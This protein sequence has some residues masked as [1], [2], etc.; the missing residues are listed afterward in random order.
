MSTH[1]KKTEWQLKPR[2]P[3]PAAKL[4]TWIRSHLPQVTDIIRSLYIEDSMHKVNEQLDLAATEMVAIKLQLVKLLKA[5]NEKA[6]PTRW[7]Q[8]NKDY[9]ELC[10]EYWPKGYEEYFEA[11]KCDF[12]SHDVQKSHTENAI[13]R[14]KTELEEEFIK[15]DVKKIKLWV[16]PEAPDLTDPRF[17]PRV[18]R[19]IQAD[20]LPKEMVQ[21][22]QNQTNTRF[23]WSKYPQMILDK[24]KLSSLAKED[25]WQSWLNTAAAEL[26]AVQSMAAFFIVFNKWEWRT[27]ALE[28]VK[29]RLGI[30]GNK[31]SLALFWLFDAVELTDDNWPVVLYILRKGHGVTPDNYREILDSP[32]PV[33]TYGINTLHGAVKYLELVETGKTSAL[34]GLDQRASLMRLIALIMGD[35]SAW[36]DVGLDQEGVPW[37]GAEPRDV[38][39]CIC[40]DM[41]NTDADLNRYDSNDPKHMALARGPVKDVG[42]PRGF[43]AGK[44]T[45][46][47]SLLN[48]L[49][50]RDEPRMSEEDDILGLSSRI[51]WPEIYE[52]VVNPEWTNHQHLEM[53]AEKADII[54]S[55]INRNYP[56]LH[57]NNKFLKDLMRNRVYHGEEIRDKPLCKLPRMETPWGFK[58]ISL[59]WR[60]SA[61]KTNRI[62]TTVNGFSAEATVYAS[63]Y[64][65]CPNYPTQ[66]VHCTESI[67]TCRT[68]LTFHEE[69]NGAPL[70]TIMDN[71]L[72]DGNNIRFLPH[73]HTRSVIWWMKHYEENGWPM[74]IFAQEMGI[75]TPGRR[76]HSK[77]INP[78]SCFLSA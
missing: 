58:L 59:P 34:W 66:L 55:A 48:L 77:D 15:S 16:F 19:R 69:T 4:V 28:T 25:K 39:E 75:P 2:G 30:Q 51:V 46:A 5:Y 44:K 14:L 76:I 45:A 57:E 8:V 37:E 74:E 63:K 33:D 56:W 9:P 31:L 64:D 13:L 68:G 12:L 7:Q 54:I 72:S 32:N 53:A 70:V 10:A 62:T 49:R 26:K 36:T 67:E 60:R 1:N 71:Y 29:G 41:I 65:P 24:F 35:L 11:F 22:Q 40:T 78:K 43:S 42:T 38:W 47:F 27:R 21:F 50:E 3:K 17:K 18:T 73:H 52:H 61:I 20:N 6:I 23:G